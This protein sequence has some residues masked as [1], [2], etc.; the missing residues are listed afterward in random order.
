MNITVT[1]GSGFIGSHV[2]DALR[3]EGH[4]VTN[5]DMVDR[6]NADT[7]EKAHIRDVD[8]IPEALT[9]NKIELVFFKLA[10]DYTERFQA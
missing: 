5:I 10:C 2:I 3:N 9:K 1:G 6:G 7:F 4:S 8:L